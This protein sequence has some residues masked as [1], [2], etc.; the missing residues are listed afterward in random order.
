M[1]HLK[2]SGV[3][4]IA[5]IFAAILTQ[6]LVLQNFPFERFS[7]MPVPISRV[8]MRERGFN[9]AEEITAHLA[10][11]TGMSVIASALQRI[12]QTASQTSFAHDAER[13]KNVLGVFRCIAPEKIKGENI[14]LIDDV[15]T[16]GATITECARALRAAKPKS[17]WAV[18]VA[19]RR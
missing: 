1:H 9:H 17:I 15:M 5:E 2:Y 3:R 16:T 13:V 11:A 4:G 8:R 19:G 7:L 6:H 18:A 10:A 12:R 14:L